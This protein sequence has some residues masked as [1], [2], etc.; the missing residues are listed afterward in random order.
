MSHR[1]V[2]IIPA[3][4]RHTCRGIRVEGWAL[5]ESGEVRALLPSRDAS[6]LF[7]APAGEPDELEQPAPEV[8]P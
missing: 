4:A 5:L 6:H 3:R 8:T 2:Q 1:V 7:V